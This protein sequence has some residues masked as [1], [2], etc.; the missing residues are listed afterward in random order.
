M[1]SPARFSPAGLFPKFLS[2][3][4]RASTIACSLFSNELESVDEEFNKCVFIVEKL[5]ETALV[6]PVNPV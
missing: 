3:R 5:S 1:K 6:N 2:S 4:P